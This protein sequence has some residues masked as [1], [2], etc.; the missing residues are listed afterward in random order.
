MR[1]WTG[2]VGLWNTSLNLL[3]QDDDN[4]RLSRT[5]ATATDPIC[6]SISDVLFEQVL[7]DDTTFVWY[8]NTRDMQRINNTLRISNTAASTWLLQH[9]L[10]MESI[11][12][13]VSFGPDRRNHLTR[14]VYFHPFH[15]SDFRSLKT[16]FLLINL[17]IRP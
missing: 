4:A 8:S 6:Q 9:Q 3:P 15:K 5:L 12:T 2:S 11:F 14:F 1:R 7:P 10:R 13:F 16:H 17:K